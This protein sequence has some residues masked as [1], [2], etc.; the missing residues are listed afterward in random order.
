[1]EE[2]L[3]MDPPMQAWRRQAREAV[4]IDGVQLPA[5]SRILMMFAAANHDPRQF[6]EPE[7]VLPGHRNALPQV[8]FGTG[9][10]FCLGAPL[11]RLELEVMAQRVAPSCP[12]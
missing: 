7:A 9:A 1:V 8:A 11:A 3:R 10:H 2:S 5:G 6:P 4:E 12:A